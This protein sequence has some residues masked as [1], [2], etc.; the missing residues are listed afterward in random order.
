M[1][2]VE[3]ITFGNGGSSPRTVGVPRRHE[4]VP[5]SF[6]SWVKNEGEEV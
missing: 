4:L 1:V 5:I 2:V 6:E 3:G